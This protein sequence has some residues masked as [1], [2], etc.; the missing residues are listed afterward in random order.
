MDLFKKC[1]KCKIEKSIK[2]FSKN[3]SRKDGLNPYC[4]ECVSEKN[5]ENKEKRS[6]SRKDYYE[7]NRIKISKRAKERYLSNKQIILERSKKYREN[8]KDVISEKAKKYYSE[9]KE[10]FIEYYN[11]NKDKI[12]LSSKLY[13]ENNSESILEKE[14]QYRT[15]NRR[16]LALKAIDY[17]Y[18]NKDKCNARLNEYRRKNPQKFAALN[19]KRRAAKIKATPKWLTDKD[20]LEIEELY[21]CAKAFQIYTGQEYHVDHI[22]PLQGKNVCGLHVP[23][24]LQLITAKENLAKSNKV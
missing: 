21:I 17:Y 15:N 22:I 14:A 10:K 24:N 23:W 7:A 1:S 19:A 2:F 18:S 6:V 16:L 13:R 4:K 20:F 12:K 11:L 3:S 8:N 9:N 5:R